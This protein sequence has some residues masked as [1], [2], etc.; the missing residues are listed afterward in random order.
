[1]GQDDQCKAFGSSFCS[2]DFYSVMPI[3]DELRKY[4]QK[5]RSKAKRASEESPKIQILQR[6]VERVRSKCAIR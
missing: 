3:V 4:V 1:M 5:R 6:M 2:K